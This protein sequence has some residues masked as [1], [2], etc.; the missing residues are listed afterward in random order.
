MSAARATCADEPP[1]DLFFCRL[2]VTLAPPSADAVAWLYLL[3]VLPCVPATMA[4]LQRRR[5]RKVAPT[6]ELRPSSGSVIWAAGSAAALASDDQQEEA[7]TAVAPQ[8]AAIW[9]SQTAQSA[10]IK[11]QVVPAFQSAED[12]GV[13]TA[14]RRH[15]KK[16]RGPV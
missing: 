11:D 6:V 16:G 8:T 9:T 10:A 15:R 5:R 2:G 4:A 12:A 14:V 1:P 7:E 13:A 3:L